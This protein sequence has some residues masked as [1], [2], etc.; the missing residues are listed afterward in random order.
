MPDPTPASSCPSCGTSVRENVYWSCLAGVLSPRIYYPESI[1]RENPE[2][3]HRF[4][5][6]GDRFH[7]PTP[8]PAPEWAVNVARSVDLCGYEHDQ[9][10]AAP[11]CCDE[12]YDAFAHLLAFVRDAALREAAGVCGG[13]RR[14]EV[15]DQHN[16]RE[17]NGAAASAR[18]IKRRILSLVGTAPKEAT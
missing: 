2:I 4:A 13:S 18:R 12:T 5:K 8:A 17:A 9:S 6:C 15:I 16:G 14:G 11:G 10:C 3:A 7:Y 1:M